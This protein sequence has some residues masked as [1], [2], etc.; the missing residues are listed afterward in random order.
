MSNLRRQEEIPVENPKCDR[1][2][3]ICE[4]IVKVTKEVGQI[5]SE[6]CR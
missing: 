2:G 1:V 5:V 4:T 6:E 3:E